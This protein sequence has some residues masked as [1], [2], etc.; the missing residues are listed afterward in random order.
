VKEVLGLQILS[1]VQEKNQK[2]GIRFFIKKKNFSKAKLVELKGIGTNGLIKFW[3][4]I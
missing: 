2:S 1:S 3:E 4:E